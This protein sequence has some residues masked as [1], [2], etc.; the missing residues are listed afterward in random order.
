ML[1]GFGSY[2]CWFIFSDMDPNDGKMGRLPFGDITNIS[3][4]GN[5]QCGFINNSQLAGS[6]RHHPSLPR[7]RPDPLRAAEATQPRCRSRQHPDPL[8]AA[9]PSSRV[10]KYRRFVRSEENVSGACSC[11]NGSAAATDGCF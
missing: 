8:R 3:V 1:H 5:A 11:T 2:I 6:T 7:R 9:E 10:E 4:L